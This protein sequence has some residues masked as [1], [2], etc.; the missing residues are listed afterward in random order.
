[1]ILEFRL[2]KRV[3]IFLAC[4]DVKHVVALLFEKLS[5]IS[6]SLANGYKSNFIFHC[7]ILPSLHYRTSVVRFLPERSRYSGRRS[8]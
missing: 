2:F 8:K 1:M 4:V 5:D 7:L 3:K 6:A